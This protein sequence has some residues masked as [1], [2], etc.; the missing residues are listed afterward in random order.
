MKLFYAAYEAISL[1]LV[2]NWANPRANRTRA[3]VPASVLT[4][5]AFLV[6]PLLSYAEHN[7]SVRPSLSL[8]GYLLLSL[9]CDAVRVR[10]LW[11]RSP[12]KNATNT[13]ASLALKAVIL[14]L[15]AL[16]KRSI[17]R[18]EFQQYPQEAISGFYSRSLFWWLNLLLRKGFRKTLTVN[19]L[20]SLD[21]HLGSKYLHILLQTSWLQGMP[22]N[23]SQSHLH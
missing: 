5:I 18:P 6:L 23:T 1:C 3:S 20:Y 17:L 19:D 15:E 8:N 16:E 7:K 2:V 9:F 22:S 14:V 4:L 12:D 13:T 11:L 21:R 10:T